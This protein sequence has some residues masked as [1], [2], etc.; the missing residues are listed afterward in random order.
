MAIIN[1]YPD[2]RLLI[3]NWTN[4]KQYIDGYF[5]SL[6]FFWTDKVNYYLIQTEAQGIHT[7]EVRVDKDSGSDQTDF[8]NNFK[9]LAPRRIGSNTIVKS[10][11]S[12]ISSINASVTNVTIIPSNTN[13]IGATIFNTSS[14]D[15]YIKLGV[16]AA[17]NSFSVIISSGGYYETPYGYV[18]QVD[19]IWIA[20]DGKAVITELT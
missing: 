2:N 20:A 5:S 13:R 3:D 4:F 17:L 12:T 14:N 11:V 18:G 16:T 6:A 8:E 7:Y 1:K 15:L 10:S 9:N 19:G